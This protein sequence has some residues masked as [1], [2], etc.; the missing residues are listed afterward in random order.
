M[1]L[2]NWMKDVPDGKHIS[3]LYIVGSHDSAAYKIDEAL[4][5]KNLGFYKYV[6]KAMRIPYVG[7]LIKGIV[8]H[9][10]ITQR[11]T[12]REQLER[13]IR[14]LDL[15][16][17]E[18]EISKVVLLHHRFGCISLLQA[19][20]EVRDFLNDNPSEC[21]LVKGIPTPFSLP[22]TLGDARGKM[23]SVDD[24]SVY[25]WVN[26]PTAYQLYEFNK[27]MAKFNGSI[28]IIDGAPT[29]TFLS[30]LSGYTTEEEAAN[31]AR[32]YLID[33]GLPR[34]FILN[35]DFVADSEESQELIKKFIKYSVFR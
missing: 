3:D 25:K 8:E 9:I 2:N 30:L 15:R 18:D 22:K 14:F 35:I 7:K 24:V 28:I 12:I 29:P 13:G 26:K 5:P 33:G 23:I 6:L 19:L 1:Y 11:Y 20:N 10:S 21:V 32:L 4:T 34:G 31:I 16:V 27:T 17:I